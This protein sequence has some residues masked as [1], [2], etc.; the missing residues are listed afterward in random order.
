MRIRI[1]ETYRGAAYPKPLAAGE[2]DLPD[3][4]G[5]YLVCTFAG[6]PLFAHE[7]KTEPERTFSGPEPTETSRRR[8]RP[9][10]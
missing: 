9:K 1:A 10:A 3:E 6:P 4:V 5:H 7:V 8:T 2:H